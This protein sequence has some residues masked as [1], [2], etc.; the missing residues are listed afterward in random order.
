MIT[1]KLLP[2]YFYLSLAILW[3]Y[4]GLVP[5]LFNQA[6]SLAMLHQMHIPTGLDWVLFIGASVVDVA[7]GVLILTKFRYNPYLWLIQFVTV[8]VYS[9]LIAVFLPENFTHPFAPLIKNVPILAM[10]FWLYQYHKTK[11]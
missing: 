8:A 1:E 11:T 9:V 7:Y 5:I 6:D 10:L 2:N 4:S 3:L